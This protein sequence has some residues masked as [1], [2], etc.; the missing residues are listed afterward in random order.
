MLDLDLCFLPFILGRMRVNRFI[1]QQISLC[2]QT[3]HL[4]TRAIT[5]I[6]TQDTL[7]P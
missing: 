1:V 2:I 5:R 7:L 6:N 3:N 4:T